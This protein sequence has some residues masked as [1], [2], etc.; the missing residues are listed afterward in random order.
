MAPAVASQIGHLIFQAVR[1]TAAGGPVGAAIG[2]ICGGG[3]AGTG[4]SGEAA[5]ATAGSS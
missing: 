2:R 4:V 5:T 1:C 3:D